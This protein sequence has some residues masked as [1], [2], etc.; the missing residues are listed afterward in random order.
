MREASRGPCLRLGGDVWTSVAQFQD[1][2]RLAY[3]LPS[4]R[5]HFELSAVQFSGLPGNDRPLTHTVTSHLARSLILAWWRHSISFEVRPLPPKPLARGATCSLSSDRS[6]TRIIEP[7][8]NI[9]RDDL[10]EKQEGRRHDRHGLQVSLWHL[11]DINSEASATPP[12]RG[13]QEAHPQP[14]SGSRPE[15]E[16]RADHS[17]VRLQR[18]AGDATTEGDCIARCLR[19]QP[20]FFAVGAM[21][22]V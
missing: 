9:P 10:L 18:E 14:R 11:A 15:K 7:S 8:T 13:S 22:I 6:S 19:A 16:S 17:G 5:D 21:G 1:S 20:R 12:R 3:A 4:S 2:L